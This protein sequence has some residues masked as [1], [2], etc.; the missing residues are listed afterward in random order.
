MILSPLITWSW[1]KF[2]ADPMDTSEGGEGRST[3]PPQNPS[4][5]EEIGVA[6]P[7]A[8]DPVVEGEVETLQDL[9][10]GRQL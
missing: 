7:L 3:L 2:F 9:S 5:P 4:P 1:D 6:P 8:A 10:I